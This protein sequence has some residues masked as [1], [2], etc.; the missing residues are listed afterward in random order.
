MF[1]RAHR[2]CR[3]LGNLPLA[4][5]ALHNT[6]FMLLEQGKRREAENLCLREIK[7]LEDTF[8]SD[9]PIAAFAL[10]PMA[11]ACYWGDDIER[12]EQLAGKAKEFSGQ[13]DL[14]YLLF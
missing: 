2:R 12:A 1:N 9:S 6:A 7:L 13:F 4:M 10:I 11:S 14:D 5:C 8:G 3:K